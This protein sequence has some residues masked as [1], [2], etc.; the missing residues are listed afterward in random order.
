MNLSNE[1]GYSERG[2]SGRES[3]GGVKTTNRHLPK[4]LDKICSAPVC[5]FLG[6]YL[7]GHLPN[8]R[9]RSSRI[10]IWDS[11]SRFSVIPTLLYLH[12]SHLIS[13]I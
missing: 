8:L 3:W 11:N 1:A 6:T 9:R 7:P 4:R 5:W 2:D 13:A 10:K 12:S